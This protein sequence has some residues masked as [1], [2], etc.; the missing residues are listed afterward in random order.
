MSINRRERAVGLPTIL[1]CAMVGLAM[2]AAFA[3]PAIRHWQEVPPPPPPSL[4]LE[5]PDADVGAGVGY[6]FGLAV[7]PDGRRLVF[8]TTRDGR[9]SLRMRDL[10][11]GEEHALPVMEGAVM[12]FWS[13]DGSRV[14]YFAGGHLREL[15]VASGVDVDRLPAPSPRGGAWLPPGDVLLAPAVNGPLVRVR[16]GAKDAEPFTEL[17]TTAGEVSHGMPVVARDGRHL[18]FHVR[19]TSSARGGIWWASIDRPAERRRLVG[20]DAHGVLSDERLLFA[21]DTALMAQRIDLEAGAL[22]GRPVMLATPVGHGPLGQ[23]FVAVAEEGPLLYSAPASALRT[24]TWVD[25]SGAAVGTLGGPADSWDLRIAPRPSAGGE[26]VAV[27]QADA[28]LGTLDVWAYEGGRPLPLRISPAIDADDQAVWSPDASRIAWVQGRRTVMVRGA[29]SV[30]PEE[31]A[32][33]FDGPVR[34]WDWSPDGRWLIIGLTEASS[35]D[36]LWMLSTRGDE[37]LRPLV[38]SPF[39]DTDAVVSPDSRWIAY[40]SDDSGHGEIYVDSF[41]APGH[42]A[43]LTFGGGVTPRWRGNGQ[44]LF[45]RRDRQLHAIALSPTASGTLEAHRTTMLFEAS[46]DIRAYDVTKDGTRVLLNLP[47][48]AAA[49]RVQVIVNWNADGADR[50]R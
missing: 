38:R 2:V 22:L 31:A 6:P 41:P 11:T 25:R 33:R 7:A 9:V 13:A 26:R 29:Q 45:F 36:D 3:V 24:L 28:Q 47:A 35:R 50:R 30:L 40:T 44:E 17:D 42:R 34:L 14:A 16:A 20:S 49:P 19:A 4:R 39:R 18:I 48:A 8:P 10:A 21:S 43:R 32:R 1:L 5:L 37:E 46:S 12:P 15:N 23:I 27:T